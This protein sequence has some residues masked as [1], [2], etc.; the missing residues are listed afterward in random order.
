M[1]KTKS[2]TKSKGKDESPTVKEMEQWT[3]AIDQL[4][5][6]FNPVRTELASSGDCSG[7]YVVTNFQIAAQLL[8]DWMKEQGNRRTRNQEKSNNGN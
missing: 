5:A 8:V 4:N 2:K 6:A 3:G 7:M 1:P